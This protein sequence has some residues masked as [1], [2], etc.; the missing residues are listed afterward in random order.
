MR[1][2]NFRQSS[3]GML[4][5]NDG[6]SDD[7]QNPFGIEREEEEEDETTK[8]GNEEDD[9]VFQGRDAETN[10]AKKKRRVHFELP[11]TSTSDAEEMAEKVWNM[12]NETATL[13]GTVSSALSGNTQISFQ[14]IASHQERVLSLL[15]HA[16]INAITFKQLKSANESLLTELSDANREIEKLRKENAALRVTAHYSSQGVFS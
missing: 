2:L 9:H 7:D 16:T 4:S 3:D 8:M 15:H 13:S 14:E 12:Q 10:N 6:D 11:A 1:K 5:A